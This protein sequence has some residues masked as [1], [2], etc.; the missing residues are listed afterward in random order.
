MIASASTQTFALSALG[1]RKKEYARFPDSKSYEVSLTSPDTHSWDIASLEK[2]LTLQLIE[3]ES[4]MHLLL[5]KWILK[6][7]K[8]GDGAI[9][10]YKARLVAGGDDRVIERDYN[11]TYSSLLEMNSGEV[12]LNAARTWGVGARN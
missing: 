6:R 1:S 9:E 5:S 12:M 10:R 3:G 2:D 11:L 7:H 8:D 4:R